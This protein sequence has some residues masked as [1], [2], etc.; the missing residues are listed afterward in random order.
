MVAHSSSPIENFIE[1]LERL[2]RTMSLLSKSIISPSTTQYFVSSVSLII[3]VGSSSMYFPNDFGD[4]DGAAAFSGLLSWIEAATSLDSN[5]DCRLRYSSRSVSAKQRLTVT[6]RSI[7]NAICSRIK[8]EKFM[9]FRADSQ[10][11]IFLTMR[12]LSLSSPVAPI[13]NAFPASW[14]ARKASSR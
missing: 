6:L 14:L 3:G 4:S 8:A 7:P 10:P 2:P 5:S 11:L 12:V 9:L 13:K 1:V